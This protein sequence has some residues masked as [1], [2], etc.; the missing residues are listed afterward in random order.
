MLKQP[1]AVTKYYRGRKN[2]ALQPL[3]INGHPEKPNMH[4]PES[5]VQIQIWYY[6]HALTLFYRNM[7]HAHVKNSEA[8]LPTD[9]LISTVP[10]VSPAF[11]RYALAA[12][13]KTTCTT[14]NEHK[15]L[16]KKRSDCRKND[17]P[18]V[19]K[20]HT[21]QRQKCSSIALFTFIL[22]YK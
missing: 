14:G 8:Y 15:F 10:C 1:S 7:L 17:M 18:Q 22:A 5:R 3:N 13:L 4:A 11:L 21:G 12:A 20:N 9:N 2:S 16:S 19:G 6:G